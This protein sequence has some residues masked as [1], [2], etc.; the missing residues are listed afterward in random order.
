MIGSSKQS[1]TTV[2]EIIASCG[3][4]AN[5]QWVSQYPYEHEILFP[6]YTSLRAENKSSI[7]PSSLLGRNIGRII[8]VK[9][10]VLIHTIDEIETIAATNNG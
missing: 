3:S 2:F 8:Q 5:I 7:V 6:P 1:T 10:T 9:A 4:G